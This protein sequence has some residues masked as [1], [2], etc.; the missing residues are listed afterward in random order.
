MRPSGTTSQCPVKLMERV[1]SRAAQ[2]RGLAGYDSL[3]RGEQTANRAHGFRQAREER[4]DGRSLADRRDAV[5][6]RGRPRAGGRAE[7]GAQRPPRLCSVSEARRDVG[8]DRPGGCF[9]SSR[10]VTAQAERDND[11][12]QVARVER[13]IYRDRG[14]PSGYFYELSSTELLTLDWQHARLAIRAGTEAAKRSGLDA[15]ESKC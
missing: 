13:N 5:S 15:W 11:R 12:Q 9:L 4:V 3:G 6:P 8:D 10:T 7:P 1:K 2:G 14:A